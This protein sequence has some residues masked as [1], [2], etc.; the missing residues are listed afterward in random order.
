MTENK[1]T[2]TPTPQIAELSPSQISDTD[3]ARRFVRDW[4]L[5]H[6]P[7]DRTFSRYIMA[8]PA[9]SN[10]LAGD[11]AWQL[12]KAL[13]A[14]EARDAATAR[15]AIELLVADDGYAVSF[16]SIGQYRQALLE[17]VA[18]DARKDGDT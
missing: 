16:Q 12:A 10:P 8:D 5:K 17:A 3:S 7:T 1:T 18:R 11:F 13:E 9:R 2:A 15:G 4:H 6:F 14:M